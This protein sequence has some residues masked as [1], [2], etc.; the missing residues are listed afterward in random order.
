[1]NFSKRFQVLVILVMIMYSQALQAQPRQVIATAGE[2]FESTNY[3][4]SFTLSE[5]VIESLQG[6][7]YMLTQGFH[8]PKLWI[9]SIHETPLISKLKITAF[10]NPATSF[11]NVSATSEL[12]KGSSYLVFNN[13]GSLV[14]KGDIEPVK[15]KIPCSSFLPGNYL[16]RIVSNNETLKT[17]KIV[18]SN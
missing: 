16:L 7:S 2:A 11:I 9:T 14:A 8:Q 5:A 10:P 15:T 3:Q 13:L 4:L 1:M 18:K 17:F 6:Q 12:P